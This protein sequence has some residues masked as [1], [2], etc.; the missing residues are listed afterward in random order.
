MKNLNVKTLVI[1]ALCIALSFVLSFVK[2]GGSIAFDALPAFFA[3]I[4]LGPVF[5]G[6]VGFFGHMFTALSSGFMFTLPIHLVIA[7]MM[8]VSCYVFGLVYK[9]TNAIVAIIVGI[10]MN[11]PVSLGVAAFAMEIVFG[12]GA[13]I[14]ML[15]GKVP[16]LMF[17]GLAFGVILVIGS[18][19]NVILATVLYDRTKKHIKL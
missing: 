15:T 9:K 19:L 16:F 5:G 2:L 10:L 13:G 14:G 4:L 1:M 3:A 18:A 8:F 7:V 12:K 6:I 11:G 17:A